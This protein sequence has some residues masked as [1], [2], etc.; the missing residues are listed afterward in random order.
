MTYKTISFLLLSLFLFPVVAQDKINW[1][2]FEEAIELNKEEPRHIFIDVYT[3]WC[4][5]CKKMDATTFVDPVIVDIMNEHFYAV[6]FDAERTDTVHFM[7]NDFI[8]PNPEGRRSTHQLAQVLLNGKLS[9]PSFTF[10]NSDLQGIYILNGYRKAPELE[11]IL[12]FFG[13]GFYREKTW[14]QFLATFV[15][16]SQ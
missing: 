5:W 11:Q 15:S 4:G 2:S 12:T 13:E 3:D 14:D 7:D 8:N 9:Y 6:K 10:L 16:K 1:V